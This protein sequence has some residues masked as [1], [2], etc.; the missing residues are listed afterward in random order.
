MNCIELVS[1]MID[2]FDR[3][4]EKHMGV[5]KVKFSIFLWCQLQIKHE[6]CSKLSFVF[7]EK[8]AD[9]PLL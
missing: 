5:Y 7:R 2:L 9:P 4:T 8:F 3:I 1:N 6:I